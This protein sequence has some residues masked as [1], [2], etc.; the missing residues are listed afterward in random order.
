MIVVAIALVT[1]GCAAPGASSDDIDDLGIVEI[2]DKKGVGGS[3]PSSVLLDLT[4]DGTLDPDLTVVGATQT[5]GRDGEGMYLDGQGYLSVAD[6]PEFALAEE[7]TLEVWL[8]FDSYA[9]VAGVLHK[10]NTADITQ[11]AW[12]LHSWGLNGEMALWLLNDAGDLLVVGS[13]TQLPIGQW[14]YVVATWDANDVK[15]FI[16][17]QLDSSVENTIGAIRDSNAPL[18]IGAEILNSGFDGVIDD[19]R[20]HSEALGEAEIAGRYTDM[21]P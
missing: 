18:F 19:V 10:G 12:L 3:T 2:V 8:R 17:G 16:N 11:E 5:V 21:V 1:V 13:S 20:V 7:G 4:F 15:I 14:H 9:G 6:T